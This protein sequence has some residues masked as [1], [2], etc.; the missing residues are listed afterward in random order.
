MH[1]LFLFF[2][3]SILPLNTGTDITLGFTGAIA[4]A[5]K[6]H[7]ADAADKYEFQ[8]IIVEP[9]PIKGLVKYHSR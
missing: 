1:G 7:I 6:D 8:N 2:E 9:S 5:F 4:V 3:K